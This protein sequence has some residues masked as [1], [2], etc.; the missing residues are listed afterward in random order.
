MALGEG[1]GCLKKIKNHMFLKYENYNS[2]VT[3]TRD[4]AWW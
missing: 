4:Y 2:S 3:M 1:G